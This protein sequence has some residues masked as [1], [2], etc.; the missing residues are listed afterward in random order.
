V[1]ILAEEPKGTFKPRTIADSTSFNVTI[2]RDQSSQSERIVA[3]VV[4]AFKSVADGPNLYLKAR[5]SVRMTC[6]S[7]NTDVTPQPR[8]GSGT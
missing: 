1:Q 3:L 7:G 8:D 2:G 4:V 6:D 5:L